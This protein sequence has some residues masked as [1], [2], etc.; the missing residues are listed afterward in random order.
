MLEISLK[1]YR[2]PLG[3]F[4]SL[5]ECIEV[6]PLSLPTFTFDLVN[7]EKI[8][9]IT[10]TLVTTICIYTAVLT[11]AIV[12][13]AFIDVCKRKTRLTNW[14]FSSA[15]NLWKSLLVWLRE[16]LVSTHLKKKAEPCLFVV[17]VWLVVLQNSCNI[18]TTSRK[19]S[20]TC[21][22]S[23]D[24]TWPKKGLCPHANE[25]RLCR[26]LQEPGYVGLFYRLP[27]MPSESSCWF[28]SPGWPADIGIPN[29]GWIGCHVIRKLIFAV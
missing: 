6:F 7:V 2:T 14:F 19:S 12:G 23:R 8:S 26:W 17:V 4:G 3:D 16:A 25:L 1:L 18:V 24:R 21:L 28:D 10:S 13:L 9:F 11:A 22:S 29:P 5:I 15:P 27:F 20:P